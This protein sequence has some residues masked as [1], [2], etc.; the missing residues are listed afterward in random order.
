MKKI[1]FIT[2]IIII[3]IKLRYFYYYV[4]ILLINYVIII[5]FYPSDVLVLKD[6]FKNASRKRGGIKELVLE[7]HFSKYFL[8]FEKYFNI[9]VLTYVFNIFQIL[10][11]FKLINSTQLNNNN[12]NNN[13]I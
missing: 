12:N 7:K 11:V 8:Q 10:F 4:L 1:C 3:I 13:I 5:F 2:F 9:K 6:L